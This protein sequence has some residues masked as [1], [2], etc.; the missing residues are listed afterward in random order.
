MGAP[1]QDAATVALI[2]ATVARGRTVQDLTGKK[3]IAGE[4]V[5]LPAADVARLRM[6]GFLV[7]PKKPPIPLADGP[8]FG[9][10][11]GPRIKRG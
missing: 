10:A 6:R 1:T 8:T 2:K 5:A 11:G 4:E 3:H 9:S 7:D